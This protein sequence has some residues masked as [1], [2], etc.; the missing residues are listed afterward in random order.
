MTKKQL[1]RSVAFVLVA[2]CMLYALCDLFE[3]Q[4]SYISE[5]FKTFRSLEEDTV[6]AVIIGTSGIDRYWNTAKG[7]EEYGLTV[8]PL[9]SDGMPS[10]LTISMLKE[11]ER[12]QDIKLAVIDIRPFLLTYKGDT[13]RYDAYSRKV[14][15]ALGFFSSSRLD[16]INRTQKVIYSEVEGSSRFDLSFFLSFIKYHSRWE[17]KSFS[18]DELKDNETEYLGF[19]MHQ[20]ASIAKMKQGKEIYTTDERMELYPLCEQILYELFDYLDDK[21]YE[22]LFIN[23][24]HYLDETEA[25]RLNT[26]CDILDEKGYNYVNYEFDADVYSFTE[27]FYNDGHTN[28]YGAEK[29]T[30]IF[31]EYLTENYDFADRRNDEKCAPEWEGVYDKMKETIAQWEENAAKK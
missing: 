28:F 24:P 5:N 27:D 4:N 23:T 18:F 9:A 6:D 26:V 25:A 17:E 15:D 20:K 29:F 13:K 16:A 31:G 1:F 22:V 7:Y 12:N 14:I 3:F 10:W 11:A 30:K 19:L 2:A 21:D 8:Y